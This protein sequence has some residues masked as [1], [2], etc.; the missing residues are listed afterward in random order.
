[1]TVMGSKILSP[2]NRRCADTQWLNTLP[3]PL[4]PTA[5][6]RSLPHH[7]YI[8]IIPAAN[9]RDVILQLGGAVDAH[10]FCADLCGNGLTQAGKNG[11]IVWGEPWDPRSWEV[12]EEFARKWHWLLSRV[13]EILVYTNIW[14]AKRDEPCLS[15]DRM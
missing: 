5:L 10:D 4:Q 14:R 6:Q 8:D 1:M 11:V 7:P 12:T 9:L 2:F 15:F 13:P 3:P